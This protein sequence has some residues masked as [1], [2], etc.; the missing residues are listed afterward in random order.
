M[1]ELIKFE[2]SKIFHKKVLYLLA[3]LVAMFI[4]LPQVITYNQISKDFGGK[5]NIKTLASQFEGDKYTISQF[6]N[7][8]KTIEKKKKNNEE[9][10]KRENFIDYYMQY[11]YPTENEPT[12]LVMNKY[13]TH[14]EIKE[15]LSKLDKNSYEYN[16]FE[17]AD[18]MISKLPKS[19][20]KY[21]GNWYLL[22]D[23][24][25][26]GTM[27][28]ML[29]VLG[30]AGIFSSEY[31]SNIAP[32]LLSTKNGKRKLTISKIL[33]GVIYATVVFIFVSLLYFIPS[34]T[35]GLENGNLPLNTLAKFSST[36]YDITI[37]EYYLS[38]LAISFVAT[39]IFALAIMLVSLLI[40]SNMISFAV[41]L[42]LYFVPALLA[43]L[44]LPEMI[45]NIIC[46]LSFAEL[47]RA[48]SIFGKFI[49]FNIFGNAVIYPYIAIV[50]MT[51]L[52]II[53]P[54]IIYKF[55]KRQ[56]LC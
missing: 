4:V 6:Q 34:L 8:I 11:N 43:G 18:E 39:I 27:K 1:I 24:N 51:V 49:T 41:S 9:L 47:I 21:T 5:E 52:L 10:T 22:L 17:K 16:A 35:I 2:L 42:G 28:L 29:L 50:A 13:Y 15:E 26:A 37:I 25:V 38:T 46:G 33:A 23:F 12:Y 14:S 55:G 32:L 20:Y 40:K 3:I 7:D 36:P 31:S 54:I 56:R 30:L 53:S 19:Q 45:L 44:P 48:A